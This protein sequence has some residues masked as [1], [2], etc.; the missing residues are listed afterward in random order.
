MIC[1]MLRKILLFVSLIGILISVFPRA[2]SL[3]DLTGEESLPG[4][5]IGVLHWLNTALR[6]QLDLATSATMEHANVSHFGMNV[7][8]QLE[9]S[10]DVREE[11]FRQLDQAGF[12]FVRQSFVW[13]D[14]EHHAKGDFVDKRNLNVYPD[15]VS[16]WEKYDN[17]AMLANK[18]NIEI[19]ARIDNPPV[20]S[21]AAGNEGGSYAP[22]D[23]FDDYGDFVAAVVGRY[24]GQI[25]YFQLWNEPN[26]NGEWGTQGVNPE[27]FT[28]LLCIGY[29]RA[30][31]A[32][33]DAVIVAPA[34]TPTFNVSNEH[35]NDLIFMQRMYDAGAGDCFDVM[36]AQ[37]Y[38]LRS[39]PSDQRLQW[40]RVNFPYHLFMRD[41]MVANGDAEKPIWISETGWNMVP[42]D[43][44]PDGTEQYG[45]VDLAEQARY[46]VE[47]YERVQREWPW[48]GV[49]NYWFLKRPAPEP[50]QQ[51][52][53]FRVMEPNFEPLPVWDALADY[54]PDADVEAAVKD[55]WRFRPILFQLSAFIFVITLLQTM[56]PDRRKPS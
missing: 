16:A 29:Q 48:I 1:A 17:L 49:A 55:V 51:S 10:L 12:R 2:G 50:D 31:A 43:L 30:K 39:G 34:L 24:T 4:Q 44:F 33:P 22:P 3:Y 37:G 45:R 7:F 26:G 42:L 41:M 53:Y 21:R 52:Y 47:M 5:T 27:Q 23:N 36:S 40:N 15:G 46:A 18:Y 9:P 28:Q 32:N 25:T 11:A 8:L 56:Q 6:P 38:G 35:L 19:L 14:I 13:E 54:V 20:W